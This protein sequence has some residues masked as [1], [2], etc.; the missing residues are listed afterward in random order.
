MIKNIWI[1][2]SIK[3]WIA[4]GIKMKQLLSINKK[5]DGPYRGY[6]YYS[7]IID[8]INLAKRAREKYCNGNLNRTVDP[9]PVINPEFNITQS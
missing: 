7:L 4:N 8:P 3:V 1:E 9:K 6:G 5:E 2:L